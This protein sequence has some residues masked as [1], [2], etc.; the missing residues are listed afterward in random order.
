MVTVGCSVC[1]R[2]SRFISNQVLKF[3]FLDVIE[4]CILFQ[5]SVSCSYIV[6]NIANSSISVFV[7]EWWRYRVLF[8]Q[9]RWNE[10]TH[11]FCQTAYCQA[12]MLTWW[13]RCRPVMIIQN[14]TLLFCT[15]WSLAVR[16]DSPI[17]WTSFAAG[18]CRVSWKSNEDSA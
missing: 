10:R 7:R 11:R 2:W 3:Q 8:L 12:D 18:F 4:V 17:H 14:Q 9:L 1:L 13:G 16:F 6:D 15:F 5:E